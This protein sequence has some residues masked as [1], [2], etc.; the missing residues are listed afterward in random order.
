MS[1][2]GLKGKMLFLIILLLLLSFA[3]VTVSTYFDTTNL[4]SDQVND[5]LTVKTDYFNEK[6]ST[7][8]SKREVILE[9]AA[10]FVSS[11]IQDS[12]EKETI[13]QYL[14]SQLEALKDKYGIIDIYIGYPDGSVDCGTQWIPDDPTWKA[15]ERPWYTAAQEKSGE[16]TYT[17]VYVDSDTGKPVVTISSVILD[18]DGKAN[19]VIAIDMGLAQLAELLANEKIGETGYP[20]LLDPEGRFVIH[21]AYSYN[22]DI[23]VADTIFNIDGGGLKELGEILL[24]Q[25]S[26]IVK[27]TYNNTLKAYYS[28]TI[29]GTKF[30]LVSTVTNEELMKEL[31][32][33]LLH[34]ITITV[35]SIAFFILFIVIFIGRITNVIKYIVTSMK[36]MAAGNL[37]F[38]IKTMKR[39]DEL[40]ILANEMSN[41]QHAVKGMVGSIKKETTNLNEAIAASDKNIEQLTKQL[42]SA[43][44]T[45]EQLSSG[46]EETAASTQEI[47]ATTIEIEAAI[48]TIAKRSQ[49]GALSASEISKKALTL[50]DGSIAMERVAIETQ[51]SMKQ[52]MDEA[53]T[54]SKEVE[55]IQTLTD[56]ILQIA[57]STNLLALNASIE[58]ARAGEAGKGFSVVSEEIKK[59]ATNSQE[60]GKEIQETVQKVIAVVQ[61]LSD[62][63]KQLLEYIETK[64]VDSYKDSIRVGENY[65]AD[66]DYVSELV[67][68]LSATSQELLASVKSISEYM[69]EIAKTSNEGASG[70]SNISSRMLKISKQANGIQEEISQIKLSADK[71]QEVVS[72]FIV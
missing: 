51:S 44:T 13:Q 15:N 65:E 37:A 21:P 52:A 34:I 1:K 4:L 2:I 31:N 46:I 5:Q 38:E 6:M 47:N 19:A 60:A 43:A 50:K 30:T 28:E 61:N 32:S 69:E 48:E 49:E 18:E 27:R 10:L 35:I 20:F 57:S 36:Q 62:N 11:K 29:A 22:E 17:D 45:I 68:D 33:M 16:I 24:S 3:A 59:L 70:T 41:M 12:T 58:A 66:A 40:G 63:S 72:N 56:T 14:V 8:F 67:T 25:E 9:N 26:K 64:V 53:L 39:K 71:L 42:T 23:A 54:R 55:R 7:Y